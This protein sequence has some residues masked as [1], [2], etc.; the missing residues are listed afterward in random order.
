MHYT[1]I[2]ILVPLK[3]VNCLYKFFGDGCWWVLMQFRNFLRRLIF[4][5]MCVSVA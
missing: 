5:V 3:I 1:L 2:G 4:R